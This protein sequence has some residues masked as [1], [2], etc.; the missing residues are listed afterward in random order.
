MK[1][2]YLDYAAT[3]PCDPRVLD[4]MTPFFTQTFAN[5]N[6]PHQAGQ[7]ARKHLEDARESVARL[8]NCHANEIFFTSGAT[9]S[10]NYVIQG[11]VNAAKYQPCHIVA[12]SIEHHCIIEPLNHLI[13]AGKIDVTWVNPDDNGIIYPETIES[14]IESYTALVIVHHANNQ[15]GTIEDVKTIA[16]VCQQKNVLF[17]VDAV[18]TVG[19]IPVNINDIGCDFLSFSAH[20]FYGPK[21][22]GGLF[23]KKGVKVPSLILGGDQ[24]RGQ[25]AGTVNLPGAVGLAKALSITYEQMDADIKHDY[26]LRERIIEG[27]L[28]RITGVKLNGHRENRL[29]NNINV[30]FDGV[31]SEQLLTAL[32]LSG[33]ACSMG[34]ACT[35]GRLTPS[36]VLQAIGLSDALALGALR[37]TVGRYTTH[38][39]VDY[40]LEQLVLKVNQLRS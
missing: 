36:H 33:L 11:I 32:D 20:K 1:N 21:G 7:T 25:R 14:A 10:N 30:A 24:E 2:I 23:V 29:P 37:I 5:A 38:Q 31:D 40:F 26:D 16:Q 39:D 35:A 9:E 8:L 27:I 34:S 3:T 17:L 15:I 28:S 19:H 18:Q 22:I 4:A 13:K 12:S 6:S